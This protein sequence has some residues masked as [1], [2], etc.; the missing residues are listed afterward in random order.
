MLRAARAALVAAIPAEVLLAVLLISG[1]HLPPA[2]VVAMETLVAAVVALEAAAVLRLYREERRR[3]PTRRAA[4]RAAWQ[5]LVP[6]AVR[7]LLAL[8]LKNTASLGLWLARRRHGVPRGAAAVPYFGAQAPALLVFLGAMV[9]ECFVVEI[10]LRSVGAPAALR[11]VLL[12]LDGYSILLAL[13]MIAAYV[14]RPHVVTAD[15]V[16]IRSGALFDL[17]IPAGRIA[18]VRRVRAYNERGTIRV[19]GDV[20]TIAIASQVNVELELTGPVT[21]VRPLGRTA[22]VRTVRCFADD[23][24]AALAAVAK[25]QAASAGRG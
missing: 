16:R 21:A 20:L 4:L 1:V 23:P 13:S 2:V 22:A 8:E 17:R 15:E 5:R 7:R 18:A 12:V 10:V 25:H 3:R 11:V 14:T 19:D 6:V 9:V 24:A